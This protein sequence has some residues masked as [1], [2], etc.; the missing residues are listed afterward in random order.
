MPWLDDIATQLENEG[1][2]T[3]GV[4]LR[5]STKA[6]VRV[7]TSG[8][9]SL[10]IISTGG[11]TPD[12]TQN[13]VI[14]P[15]YINPS[16]Q[17]VARAD[18]YKTA[19]AM[20]FAAYFALVKVRNQFINSGWYQSIKPL[21][22]PFDG[23]VDERGQVKVVFNVL[24]KSRPLPQAV[25]AQVDAGAAINA[26]ILTLLP[27]QQAGM[28]AIIDALLRDLSTRNAT[29][30]LKVFTSVGFPYP[31]GT[32]ISAVP[33]RFYGIF[34]TIDGTQPDMSTDFTV[35]YLHSEDAGQ[36]FFIDWFANNP[37]D[38]LARVMPNG[39]IVP[40]SMT[41]LTSQSGAGLSPR[42]LILYGDV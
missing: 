19:E 38:V 4:N 29:R 33:C 18:D 27:S 36:S 5:A 11:T 16:A 32:S 17:I 8:A 25:S 9:A 23:G 40:V 39:P 2:A 24:G 13:S 30:D 21:Q 26:W 42:V 1:V 41:F 20:A 28:R 15:A 6:A 12:G 34:G 31:A 14:T 35:T 22:Q 37:D 10:H 3:L 7:L